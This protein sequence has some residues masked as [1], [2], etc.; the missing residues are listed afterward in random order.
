MR[1]IVFL[2]H[3]PLGTELAEDYFL[4]A[5]LEVCVS[6]G[7]QWKISGKGKKQE[8]QKYFFFFFFSVSKDSFY[9]HRYINRKKKGLF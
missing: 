3:G 5:L 7:I 6:L 2:Y 1:A 4:Q 9:K 8:G